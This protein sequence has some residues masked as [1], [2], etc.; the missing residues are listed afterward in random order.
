MAQVSQCYWPNSTNSTRETTEP[1]SLLDT[2]A[3]SGECFV[4]E[5][6]TQDGTRTILLAFSVPVSDQ[7]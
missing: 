5:A 4:L 3:V 7:D 1:E 6:S 2:A